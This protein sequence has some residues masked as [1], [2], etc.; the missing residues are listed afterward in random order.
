MVALGFSLVA[1]AIL[2]ATIYASAQTMTLQKGTREIVQNMFN[3]VRL[4]GDLARRLDERQ[5]LVE[6]HIV[7]ATPAEM[8]ALDGRIAAADRRVS[9]A[10]RR[11]EPWATLPT[12]REAWDRT[13]RHLALLDQPIARALTLSRRNADVAA[14]REMASV[15]G[16]FESVDQDVDE[17]IG[18]NNSA[19][20][21]G[22]VRYEQIRRRLL[23][24]LLGVGLVSFTLALVV[25]IWASRQVADREKM[26]VTAANLLAARNRDLDAF[27]GRVAHDI[28]GVLASIT[29]AIGGAA[30]R[31]PADD[32][33]VAILRRGATRMDALVGDLLALA[34]SDAAGHGQCDPAG[35][36]EQIARDIAPR[37]EIEKGSLHTEAVHAS[38]AC[39]EG[40]LRQAV[41][42][43]VDNA[44]KYHRPEVPPDVKIAGRATDGGYELCITDNGLGMSADETA[45]VFEPFYRSPRVHDLP[46]TGL[47][48]SIVNRIA[49]AAGGKL[50]VESQLGAGTT[51][52]I[53]LPLSADS[54]QKGTTA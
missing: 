16:L 54:D 11:Y 3:S 39:N 14:R 51:F 43:L 40:L 12:E 20:N 26:M 45:K 9:D 31:L 21:A 15:D 34:R 4:L 19:A 30:K 42:N 35:V 2:V 29:L 1:S 27:A 48:L 18:I 6:R 52:A 10:M 36:V 33:S 28:R 17:L 44:I 50:S 53:R 38:V 5:L 24:T 32:R 13:R 41:I 7:A 22:L 46:G 25:G 47:G 37:I 49:E 8:G 23:F